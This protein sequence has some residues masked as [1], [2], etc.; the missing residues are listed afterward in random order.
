MPM[1][2]MAGADSDMDSLYASG[3]S[4]AAPAD[5]GAE[6][7]D[8]EEAGD[9]ATALVPM[10]ILQGKHPAPVKE[11]DEVVLKVVAVHGDEAEVAYSETKPGAIPGAEGPSANDEIDSMDKP[12]AY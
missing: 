8:Q 4:D 9:D 3:E 11:G 5:K 6:T 7:V 10:K 12:G 2:Q 1:K